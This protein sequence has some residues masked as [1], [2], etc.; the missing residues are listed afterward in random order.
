MKTYNN[1]NKKIYVQQH[2]KVPTEISVSI[3]S[4][5]LIYAEETRKTSYLVYQ[6]E[7]KKK[8][9]KTPTRKKTTLNFNECD[10][11]F[12]SLVIS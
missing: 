6:K 3:F 1:Y 11:I 4:L 12:S 10:G 9:K 2:E 5:N 8:K 7:M